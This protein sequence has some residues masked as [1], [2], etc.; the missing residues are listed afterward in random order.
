MNE[1]E[2][3]TG[4]VN[5]GCGQTPTPGWRN[6]DNS[7]SLWL[8]K[9]PLL[10][11]LLHR[12]RLLG[13][14]QYAFVRFARENR[15]QYGNA[16]KGLPLPDESCDV[17]YSSHMVEHLDPSGAEQFLKAAFRLLRPGGTIRISVPDIRKHV[18]HYI[19]TGDADA[20][21][22]ATRLCVPQPRTFRKRIHAVLVGPRHHQ[23][24]YDGASMSRLME[25]HGFVDVEV[26]DAGA[27]KIP[28]PGQLNL[29]ERIEQSVYVE[30]KKP[31]GEY[32]SLPDGGNRHDFAADR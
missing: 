10:P 23:W 11:G 4:R 7:F 28:Q 13:G 1:L 14:K 12:V 26:M 21:M 15:I 24:M 31:E 25:R 5:V 17:L 30:A 32:R 29:S 22:A 19:K 2:Q 18:D 6:F 3:T 20:F 27:T 16:V 8:A 9:L